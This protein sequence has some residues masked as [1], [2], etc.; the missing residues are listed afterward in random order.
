M[1]GFGEELI[2][3][4]TNRMYNKVSGSVK[5][6]LKFQWSGG[7]KDIGTTSTVSIDTFL[8]SD[9]FAC[10]DSPLCIRSS[11]LVKNASAV[12]VGDLEEEFDDSSADD[13][14]DGGGAKATNEGL[15][16]SFAGTFSYYSVG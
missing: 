10:S 12:R 16:S 3:V 4:P 9:D 13:D 6:N 7:E 5:K 11:K 14:D 2:I 8:H 15:W 1:L